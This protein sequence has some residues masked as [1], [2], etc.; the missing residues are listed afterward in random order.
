MESPFYRYNLGLLN[1]NFPEKNILAIKDIAK[2]E[3]KHYTTIQ[4]KYNL[5]R[6]GI[7]KV[8]YAHLISIWD[9]LS[10]TKKRDIR[11]AIS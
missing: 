5:P 9:K 10:A 11:K 8:E 7:T 4:R 6:D 3:G 2:F 1:E